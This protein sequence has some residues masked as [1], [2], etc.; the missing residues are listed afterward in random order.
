MLGG[1]EF[2]ELDLKERLRLL[3]NKVPFFFYLSFS[4][5]L[6]VSF[7][8]LLGSTLVGARSSF[9]LTMCITVDV[10]DLFSSKIVLG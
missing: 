6:L 3:M 5:L 1:H 7:Y 8:F 9:L 2:S 10:V 4:L